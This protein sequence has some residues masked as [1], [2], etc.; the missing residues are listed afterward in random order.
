M[1]VGSR[2]V[3]E[4][5]A[6]EITLERAR[7][8][9]ETTRLVRGSRTSAIRRHTWRDSDDRT[10]SAFPRTA[11]LPGPIPAGRCATNAAPLPSS[12]PLFKWLAGREEG[13]RKGEVHDETLPPAR[14][15]RPL[16]RCGE[17]NGGKALAG[18]EP[19]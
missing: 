1:D 9:T 7:V 6:T 18:G 19:G 3:S 11:P 16:G 5:R 15:S 12:F 2:L 4:E 10:R 13:M 17:I 8:R 14:Q